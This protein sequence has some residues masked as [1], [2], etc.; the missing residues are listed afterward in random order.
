M[1]VA[2]VAVPLGCFWALL[3]WRVRAE[4]GWVG[5]P[6]PRTRLQLSLLRMRWACAHLERSLAAALLP[7]IVRT[8]EVMAALGKAYTGPNNA[9]VSQETDG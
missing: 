4:Q 1:T 3:C 8:A 9:G 7:V 5:F 2:A 6:Q